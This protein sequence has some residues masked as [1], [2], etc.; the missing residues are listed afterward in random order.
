MQELKENFKNF[1]L[2][3]I[4]KAESW[5]FERI[6]GV[7]NPLAGLIRA[8]KREKPQVNTANKGETVTAVRTEI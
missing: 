2:D 3:R 6:N 5:F 1:M 8:R 7:E 4:K